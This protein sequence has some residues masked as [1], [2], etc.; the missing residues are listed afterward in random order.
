MT[1]LLCIAGYLAVG[2]VVTTVWMAIENFQEENVFLLFIAWPVFT[3]MIIP[4]ALFQLAI[5]CAN[6]IRRRK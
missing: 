2:F 4:M 6:K 3:L 1:L 5:L